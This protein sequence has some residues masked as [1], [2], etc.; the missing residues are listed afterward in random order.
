MVH[1]RVYINAS[2]SSVGDD[3]DDSGGRI[4][5]PLIV[6]VVVTVVAWQ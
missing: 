1:S 4:G 6:A 3:G 5:F 2:V